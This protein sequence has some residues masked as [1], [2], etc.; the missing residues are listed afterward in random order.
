MSPPMSMVP[1]KPAFRT[2]FP[3]IARLPSAP[4]TARPYAGTA[5]GRA[6]AG[7]GPGRRWRLSESSRPRCR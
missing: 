3:L 6:A 5:W 4:P 2:P 1:A 7:P